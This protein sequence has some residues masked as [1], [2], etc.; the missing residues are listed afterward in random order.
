M[1]PIMICLISEMPL[2]DCCFLPVFQFFADAPLK[3][4]KQK[5][6]IANID[7]IV[8]LFINKSHQNKTSLSTGQK[9]SGNGKKGKE[10]VDEVVM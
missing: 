2:L 1:S 4:A 9:S 8:L 7:V 6:I 5:I 3:S 10:R